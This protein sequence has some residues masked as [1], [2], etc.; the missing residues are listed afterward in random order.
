MLPP[1]SASLRPQGPGTR[2][3]QHP[4]CPPSAASGAALMNTQWALCEQTTDLQ[5]P[6]QVEEKPALGKKWLTC[7]TR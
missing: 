2:R 4:L 1:T 6:R 5:G 3:G 7:S